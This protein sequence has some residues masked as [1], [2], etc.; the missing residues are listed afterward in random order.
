MANEHTGG[1]GGKVTFTHIPNGSVTYTITVG[2]SGE[3]GVARYESDGPDDYAW[4]SYNTSG[5]DSTIKVGS[6]TLAN[7]KGGAR[8]TREADGAAGTVSCTAGNKGNGIIENISTGVGS[9]SATDGY[10]TAVIKRKNNK[11]E[12]YVFKMEDSK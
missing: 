11:Y 7:A 8:A 6:T 2:N 3:N 1:A 5:E 10:C 12:K 9:E 4:F